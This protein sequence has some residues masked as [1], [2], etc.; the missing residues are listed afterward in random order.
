MRKVLGLLVA[1][2]VAV[3]TGLALPAAALKVGSTTVDASS[4]DNELAAIK[5]SPMF[6]CYLEARVYVAS[7]DQTQGPTIGGVTPQTRSS[8]AAVLWAD[9]RVT[10][11]AVAPFVRAHD[12]AAFS[13]AALEAARSALGDTLVGALDGAF[14]AQSSTFSCPAVVVGGATP[15]LESGAAI[16]ATLPTWFQ[17]AQVRAE[18]ADLGLIDLLPNTIRIPESGPGLEQWYVKNASQFETTCVGRIEV[19]TASAARSIRSKIAAG[20]SFAS[21]AR[22]FS[23][24]TSTNK[25][26]GALGCYS[27]NSPAWSA[28]VHY[29]GS[30]PTGKVALWPASGAYFVFSP[31]KRTPNSYAKVEG[32]IEAQVHAANVQNAG[33]LGVSIQEVTPVSVDSWLG[34]WALDQIGGHVVPSLA[35]P[36][37]AV[38]NPTANAPTG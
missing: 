9:Q 15:R 12:P 18:A 1:A 22:R 6:E 19:L 33:D 35:P 21:A 25:K 26:G 14:S 5:A 24:D 2:A 31:T 36:S 23:T 38:T 17:D 4:F 37:A 32:A 3:I 20:L 13:P 10:Q 30:T 28:V 7:Q 11:L 34:T 29:V 16:L 27:P 8:S